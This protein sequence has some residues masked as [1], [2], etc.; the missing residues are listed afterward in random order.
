MA[1]KK[2]LF[3]LSLDEELLILMW[4]NLSNFSFMVSVMANFMCQCDEAMRFPDHLVKH[5]SG[6]VYERVSG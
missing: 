4:L 6:C 1:F 3:M 5:Y 2:K